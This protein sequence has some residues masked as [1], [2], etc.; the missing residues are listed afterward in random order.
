MNSPESPDIEFVSSDVVANYLRESPTKPP[1]RMASGL[2]VELVVS[3]GQTG[4]DRAGLDVAL[5][6]GLP[7]GGFVPAGRRT[8]D[9]ALPDSYE[10][11]TE[12]RSASYT[13]RTV[14]NVRH[15]NATLLFHFEDEISGGTALTLK[16]AKKWGRPCLSVQLHPELHPSDDRVKEVRSW[17]RRRKVQVLNVAGPR[18]SEAPGIHAQTS[19]FLL[20]VLEGGR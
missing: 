9:G 13:E 1:P 4:A 14:L 15:S 16:A 19:A 6:I 12:T 10:G 17:L 18:E 7:I 3:G 20:R 11:M 5:S 2:P 8:E